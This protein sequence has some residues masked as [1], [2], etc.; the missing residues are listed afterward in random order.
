[1]PI[2]Y[3]LYF[4]RLGKVRLR[5]GAASKFC[6]GPLR[7]RLL[8]SS[9]NTKGVP[10]LDFYLLTTHQIQAYQRKKP[11]QYSLL[12]SMEQG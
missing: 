1:M 11:S 7:L 8:I 3:H 2:K 10:Q 4:R 5:A 12:K 6:F 9:A